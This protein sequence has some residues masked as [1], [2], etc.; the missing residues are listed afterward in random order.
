MPMPPDSIR[1]SPPVRPIVLVA[2]A[3]MAGLIV[4]LELAPPSWPL[5]ILIGVCLAAAAINAWRSRRIHGPRLAG[6]GILLV[7][8]AAL[9]MWQGSDM[10]RADRQSLGAIEPW[11]HE[12]AVTIAGVVAEPPR[13]GPDWAEIVVEKA[14]IAS[15][16]RPTPEPAGSLN[17][18][19][20]LSQA[21]AAELIARPEALPIQGQQVRAEGWLVPIDGPANPSTFDTRRYWISRGIG[22]RMQIARIEQIE[23]GP[24]PA[25]WRGWIERPMSRLRTRIGGTLDRRLSPEPAKLARALV[26]GQ[27]E[28]I[29]E[30][31]RDAFRLAGWAHL[32]AVSGQNAGIV[33]L[34]V[35][36]L[37]RLCF[38]P[39]RAAAWLGIAGVLFY[40][41]LTAF[42]PT[43]T[44]AGTM[45]AFLLAGYAF[46]RQ[47]T[48]PASIAMAAF[49]TLLY[50]PRNLMRLDWQISYVCTLSMILLAPPL[51]EM[52]TTRKRE[53]EPPPAARRLLNRYIILPV[54]VSSAIQLGLLPLQIAYFRQ[55]NILIAI[56]NI[57]GIFVASV[58]TGFSMATAT[59]GW[60]PWVGAALGSIT[61]GL[62]VALGSMAGWFAGL[63]G[64]V[65]TLP[66]LA[67]VLVAAFYGL[68]LTGKWLR[69]GGADGRLDDAQRVSLMRHFGA[70][71]GLMIAALVWTPLITP[72]PTDTID[73][74]MLDVG[75]G[76]SLVLRAGG[77]T[78]VVDAGQK[79]RGRLTVEPFLRAMNID[80]IDCLV[81][82]H[83]DADH[84]GGMADLVDHFPVGRFI[85]GND[86]SDS[87]VFAQLEK[88]IAARH[89]PTIYARAGDI[90]EGFGPAK[91]RLLG[92]VPGFTDNN[93]SVVI[94]I[95]HEQINLL[96]MG[97]LEQPGEQKLEAIG[98]IRD[99]EVL[100]VGHHGSRTATG[101]A[102]LGKSKPELALIS[103]GARNRFGH[104]SPEAIERLDHAR[105]QILRTDRLG[106]VWLHSNGKRIDV[107]RYRKQSIN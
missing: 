105:S 14:A 48:R 99:V 86:T 77:K 79:D 29:S 33:L 60:I 9:G 62:L 22:A 20:R 107:Y 76:D 8:L 85:E 15:R 50:D 104:P 6:G 51:Y 98:A 78:M 32:L 2:L 43:V 84:I 94:E 91:I 83:A 89:V 90:I 67:P 10:V 72:E 42:M 68:L 45:I 106:A 21:A 93:G 46:G 59:L 97:D 28:L 3:H 87:E 38:L 47:A 58:A 54:V 61:N 11:I 39:P 95:D 82:T 75:Q 49:V 7:A 19:L 18:A 66:V 102:L 100:K 41:A 69:V 81:A 36:G 96:L 40:M 103:V 55:V 71:S 26:L 63:P 64:T 80:R 73:F 92:P 44:R 57:F 74:Y 88:D 13:I 5:K 30:D 4:G 70:A 31:A 35:I 34:L 17:I 56:S 12:P 23:I 37:A 1:I 101:A 24:R 27:A 53:D 16:E 25:G 65:L 52:A